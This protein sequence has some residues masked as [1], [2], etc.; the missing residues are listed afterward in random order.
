VI[1]EKM[2]KDFLSINDLDVHEIILMFKA[3]RKLKTKPWQPLLE[4]RNLILLFQKPS[5]R[6]MVSFEVGMN[7]LGGH[8]IYLNWEDIQLGRGETVADTAR[9]LGRYAD[10]IMARLYSHKDLVELAKY[11][12]V[13]VINGLTDLLHP[14]QVLSDMFTISEKVKHVHGINLCFLGDGGDN[15]CHSLMRASHKLGFS[16]SIGCPK[17]HKPDSKILK[18][19][20]GNVMVYDNPESAI[21]KADVVYTDTWVSMGQDMERRKRLKQ[22]KPYQLNSN[23][24]KHASPKAMVMHCLPAHRGQEI[25][26]EVMDG[27]HSIVW[28]QAENRLHVQK[29]LLSMML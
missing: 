20:S 24:L 22:L 23:L 29:A 21:R 9:V 3:V 25:T 6:T 13:P 27:P 26:A 5:T 15:V 12:G 28:D 16:M 11:A 8:A 18:E 1:G 14:C 19:T 2:Q 17:T 7:Q 4:N 10:G